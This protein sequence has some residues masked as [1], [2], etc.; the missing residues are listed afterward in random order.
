MKKFE[1]SARIVP[2]DD[3][4][5]LDQGG[6]LER[7]TSFCAQE[8]AKVAASETLLRTLFEAADD[9]IF[10]F[11]DNQFQDCNQTAEH[12]FGCGKDAL[13]GKGPLDFSPSCQPDGTPSA[14]L[15]ETHL[16][17]AMSVGR[18]RF[19]WCHQTLAGGTFETEISL[20]RVDL[21]DG[22]I[23]L[24]IARDISTRKQTLRAL[25]ESERR[26]RIVAEH[27][28]DW[29]MWIGPD[30]SIEYISPACERLSG[31]A[32]GHFIRKGPNALRELI[33]P[34][35]RPLWDAHMDKATLLDA[36]PLD[37]RIR[38]TKG[39]EVWICQVSRAVRDEN[40]KNLGVRTSLRDITK[41]KAMERQLQHAAMHDALTGLAN[42][43]LCL[44]RIGRILERSKRRY[45]YHYA[46][47]VVHLDR[48]S[49]VSESLGHLQGDDLLVQAASRIS[50]I[51]RSIDTV[52]RYNGDSFVVILDELESPREAVKVAKRIRDSLLEPFKLDTHDIQTGVSSGIVLSP[53]VYRKPED[54]LQ[55]AAVAM[56]H[57]Q[58]SGRNNFKVFT[59][60]LLEQAMRSLSLEADLRRALA[61]KD[62]FLVFQPIISLTDKRLTGFEAL[63][64]WQHPQR[65]T[66][67]PSEFISVAEDSGLIMELGDWVLE[68]ACRTMSQWLRSEPRANDIA[69]SVNLSCRQFSYHGLVDRIQQLLKLYSLPPRQL[70]LEITES[71]IMENAEV[72]VDKLNRLRELGIQLSIDDFGTG[73]SSMNHL[74]RFPLDHLKIDLSFVQQMHLAPENL[75]IVRAIIN[76]AHNLGLEVVAEGI[77]EVA[78]HGELCNLCCE[79]GQ[80][81]LFS[82]PVEEPRAL[83]ILQGYLSNR[84]QQ[85]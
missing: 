25:E 41:R 58:R 52:S 77:E 24:A 29:E 8:C 47:L 65:G 43:T 57:A 38:D 39:R 61:N 33:F 74:S 54:L 20:K 71:T 81:Y 64:R 15:M 79:Y 83:E 16:G 70:K 82:Q 45:N 30:N 5:Q 17:T 66:V 34:E 35:D 46:V 6:E 4:R 28:Y 27:T 42:R 21:Q 12:L 78:Q 7:V 31:L 60:K 13:L 51:V 32:T 50:G 80:G 68:E 76:L 2:R 37:F 26:Y 3:T 85:A 53:A 23:I 63:V 75:E 40:G 69:V 1:N 19:E 59:S 36:S 49:Q 48:Y 56:R 18:H 73:Y 11:R 72:A 22:P 67:P 14:A 62:F 44:D 55:N 10:T 84:P 9:A